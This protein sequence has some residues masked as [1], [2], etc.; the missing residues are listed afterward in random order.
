MFP[1]PGFAPSNKIC[2]VLWDTVAESI[3]YADRGFGQRGEN[4]SLIL[5]KCKEDKEKEKKSV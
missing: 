5:S 1:D 2:S 4:L 3:R